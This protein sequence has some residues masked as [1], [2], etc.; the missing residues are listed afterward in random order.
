[1]AYTKKNQFGK[2]DEIFNWILQMCEY[3]NIIL[4]IEVGWVCAAC[5]CSSVAL[6]RVLGKFHLSRRAQ[7]VHEFNFIYCRH[8]AK[9]RQTNKND[10]SCYAMRTMQCI[11]HFYPPPFR[12]FIILFF[13]SRVGTFHEHQHLASPPPPSR[14]QIKIACANKSIAS[15]KRHS[16]YIQPWISQRVL[17]IAGF[18]FVSSSA[19]VSHLNASC[20]SFISRTVQ[21]WM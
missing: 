1:M 20:F 17:F 10:S 8:R 11:S 5:A 14:L 3:G 7:L 19:F 13:H 6:Q 21:L 12:Y 16:G 18:F 15:H 4:V 2:F 9:C